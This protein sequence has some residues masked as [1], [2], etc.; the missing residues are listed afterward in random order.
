MKSGFGNKLKNLGSKFRIVVNSIKDRV[1]GALRKKKDKGNAKSYHEINASRGIKKDRNSALSRLVSF[2]RLGDIKIGVKITVSFILIIIVTLASAFF[3]SMSS[4]M[5]SMEEEATF[6]TQT[7]VEQSAKS[8]KVLLEDVNG[9]AMLIATDEE[10]AQNVKQM[11]ETDDP[12]EVARASSF[13][14]PRMRTLKGTKSDKV[15]FII[16]S[17]LKGDVTVQG[18]GNSNDLGKSHYFDTIAYKEFMRSGKNSYWVDTHFSDLIGQTAYSSE[19]NFCLFKV[20]NTATSLK[21]VG[22]L[23]VNV[24]ESTIGN[25]LSEMKLPYNG[26]IYIV[27]Q[28]W[29][30]IYNR[31]N[32]NE[33]AFRVN[34]INKINDQGQTK[35]EVLGRNELAKNDRALQEVLYRITDDE[36]GD[37][38]FKQR[39]RYITDSI[40]ERIYETIDSQGKI[41]DDIKGEPFKEIVNGE[42]MLVTYYTIRSIK[43]TQ[44]E[45]SIISL[46][47]VSEITSQVNSAVAWIIL[48][49]IL[50]FIFAALIAILITYDISSGVKVLSKFMGSIQ[51]G[52]L[53][54]EY[55]LKRKDEIG[56][57]GINF[58]DMVVNLRTLIG[59]I[60]GASN[61]AIESSQT[62]SSTSEESYASIQEF[63]TLL[64]EVNKEIGMQ[65][66]EI[67]NNEKIAQSL[68]DKIQIITKDFGNVNEI[69]FGAKELG[70]KGKDTVNS[71]QQNAQQVKVTINEF[72]ELIN[73]LRTESGEISKITEAIKGIAK[74][75]NLLAL[76]ATIE[77]ARA[78]EAGKGFAVVAHAIKK[79]AD[80]SRE[81]ASFI[82]RKL[83][84]ITN[85]IEE[86]GKVV[87][88][89]DNVISKH[90]LAV[91]DTIEKFDNI[92]DFMDDVYNQVR[93]INNSIM[94]IDE[95]R[96]D[97]MESLRNMNESSRKNVG[98]INEITVGFNELVDLIKHLVSLSDDLRKLSKN[99]ESSIDM[100]KV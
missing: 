16:A 37:N 55:N 58:R 99:L 100:F 12:G 28:N 25:V 69:I 54:I 79:L 39:D 96:V 90:D 35:A 86:T 75:T 52:N 9:L 22:Y 85:T 3:A 97:I 29:N 61:V 23:Q 45:W 10:I 88:V 17:S 89:S 77:A 42:E 82:E 84:L 66:T 81:S 72:S 63:L 80:Q 21:P 49:G 32:P 87:K 43:G 26:D 24:N 98:S 36:I 31:Q 1:S 14:F 91:H 19:H 7:I 20:I 38:G 68:S 41:S 65:K 2:L 44:L 60:K 5:K 27:G 93:S 46:T 74:Q 95:A 92:V 33:N 15:M 70:E 78:G 59:S 83:K 94:S 4:V 13:I 64:T 53:D 34:E 40:M 71:L 18:E 51:K 11:N 50:C 67:D 8:I 48:I 6:S 62:V 73:V 30:M 76:N 47:P 57:L 56:A